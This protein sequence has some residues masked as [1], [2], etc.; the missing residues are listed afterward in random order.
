[1]SRAVGVVRFLGTNCDQDVYE[2]VRLAGLRPEW[3]WYQDSF[4]RAQFDALIIPGGFSYG[5]YL[6]CGALAAR[7]PVMSSVAEAAR[8]GTPILGICNG[9]QILCEARLLPGVLLRNNGLRFRDEWVDLDLVNASLSFGGQNQKSV[10]LP[11]AHGEGR[12]Y[13]EN[14]QVKKLFDDEQVWWTYRNNPNG[15]VENIAGV[16][17]EKKN[18]AGLMPHP[19]RAIEAFMGGADGLGFFSSLM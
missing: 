19:E 5:D 12:Y 11:I 15:S 4:D 8:Y 6:R 13:L 2:A 10:R 16:F 17:N 7:A 9:F 18:V 1:M 14:D 3:I